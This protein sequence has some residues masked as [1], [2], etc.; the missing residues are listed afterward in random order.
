MYATLYNLYQEELVK[1]EE[2]VTRNWNGV[3]FTWTLVALLMNFV[4]YCVVAD[5][6]I[7]R[8]VPTVFLEHAR[9]DFV[10]KYGGGMT[11]TAPANNLNREFE[12]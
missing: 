9:E 4:A 11:I 3:A 8:Q 1:K 2:L 6:S 5:E 7:G 12:Y 10:S